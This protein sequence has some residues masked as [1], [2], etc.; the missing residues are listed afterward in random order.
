MSESDEN[1]GRP[2]DQAGVAPE[3]CLVPIRQTAQAFS[4]GIGA[5]TS[6][7]SSEFDKPTAT[8]G[9]PKVSGDDEPAWRVVFDIAWRVLLVTVGI[10]VVWILR[11]YEVVSSDGVASDGDFGRPIPLRNRR[12]CRG[13]IVVT[14]QQSV[15]GTTRESRWEGSFD[16]CC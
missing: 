11:H 7:T 13:G 14:G 8:D 10:P 2:D 1:P 12:V 6:D 16:G 4:P 15:I 5:S 9:Q 3:P